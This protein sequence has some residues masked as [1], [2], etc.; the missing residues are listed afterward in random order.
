MCALFAENVALTSEQNERL[1]AATFG[2]L[3][4]TIKASGSALG[5][6]SPITNFP[7]FE[8]LEF[9][10][11]QNHEHLAPFLQAMKGLADQQKAK[12]LGGAA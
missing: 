8:R 10:G 11:Q 6:E 4:D 3:D 1:I 7:D 2:A 5:L 12:N 9:R